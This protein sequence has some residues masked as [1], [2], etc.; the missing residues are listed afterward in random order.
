VQALLAGVAALECAGPVL[1]LA[2]DL[3]RVEPALLRLIAERP[4]GHTVIPVRRDRAQYACARYAPAWLAAARSAG[5]SSF[6]RV[7]DDTVE[8]LHEAEWQVVAPA[9]ALDDVD[10]P[11]DLARSIHP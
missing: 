8:Y 4:G 6:A 11:E 10:T 5:V 7:P 9:R 2:C 3:P 1:L